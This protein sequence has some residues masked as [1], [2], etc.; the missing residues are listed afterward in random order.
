LEDIENNFN[1]SIK[2]LVDGLTKLDLSNFNSKEER[3]IA[4]HEK[5]L[6]S[7]RVDARIIVVKLADRLHNMYTLGY[8]PK[9]K[10]IIIAQETEEF[11]VNLARLLG[12][13]QIKDAF[14]D[15]SLFYLNPND[16]IKYCLY[17]REIKANTIENCMQIGK[18]TTELL[19]FKNIDMDYDIKLKNIGGIYHDVKNGVP[20]NEIND[21]VAIR[22]I[23]NE[24]KDC[25]HAA[26]DVRKLCE[27][28]DESI[29]DTIT[30][31]KYN[32]YQS[33]NMNA[34]YKDLD[35]QIR[36]RTKKMQRVNE[37]GM[38]S[39]WSLGAQEYLNKECSKMF[40]ANK[41]ELKMKGKR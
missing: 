12:I 5:I 10:Q 15:L 33:I 7:I 34:T 37:L 16:F 1:T 4:T 26:L 25:Y 3:R 18:T 22:M 9:E 24:H 14:Q 38:V 36:I 21:L 20:L 17:R 6:E 30:K 27:V 28:K 13:Y 11:Y 29:S 41:K 35:L 23:L 32:G 8:L 31:P 19:R 39:N 2:V 40:E